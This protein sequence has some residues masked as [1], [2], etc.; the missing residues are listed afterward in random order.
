MYWVRSPDYELGTHPNNNTAV[1]WTHLQPSEPLTVLMFVRVFDPDIPQNQF[2]YRYTSNR[3]QP[4]FVPVDSSQFTRY[5][6]FN[7]EDADVGVRYIRI[8][9]QSGATT[10]ELEATISDSSGVVNA[11]NVLT[12]NA[13]LCE[14]NNDTSAQ[15]RF[16]ELDLQKPVIVQRIEVFGRDPI[17]FDFNTIHFNEGGFITLLNEDRDVTLTSLSIMGSGSNRGTFGEL[18]L[19]VV[20]DDIEVAFDNGDVTR[21]LNMNCDVRPLLNRANHRLFLRTLFDST[22]ANEA[23]VGSISTF[24]PVIDYIQ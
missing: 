10:V 12:D 15:L 17:E 6:R 8:T 14:N 4:R 20:G 22:L 11:A 23:D 9:T 16:I 18:I 19:P 21:I 13:L 1:R 2:V 7:T 3:V 5:V 24:T